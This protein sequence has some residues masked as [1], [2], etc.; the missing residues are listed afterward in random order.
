MGGAKY[1]P[2]LADMKIKCD[3]CKQ[4]NKLKYSSFFYAGKLIT[5]CE[6][7][8]WGVPVDA[9]ANKDKKTWEHINTPFWKL[10]G[11]PPKDK[12]I[13]LDQY[14]KNR[15]MTYGDYRKERDYYTAKEPSALPQF[16][17]HVKEG[18]K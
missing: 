18:G 4:K 8:R 3:Q 1:S 16:Q 15:N 5:L 17:K 13:K 7:C 14:L 2:C 11:L 9:K 10:M 12:D 6:E